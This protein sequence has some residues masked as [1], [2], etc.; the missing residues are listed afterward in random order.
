M[1]FKELPI[2]A[3]Y[4]AQDFPNLECI[5]VS[6]DRHVFKS[7]GS[8]GYNIFNTYYKYGYFENSFTP[9]RDYIH[10]DMFAS[11]EINNEKGYTLIVNDTIPDNNVGYYIDWGLVDQS[12]PIT[13]H[14]ACSCDIVSLLQQGCKCGGI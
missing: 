14:N 8:V 9:I 4:L 7:E 5:K 12:V 10:D 13:P 6:S 11:N 3:V 1:T 2:G